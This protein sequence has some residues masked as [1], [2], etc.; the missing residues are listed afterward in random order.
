MADEL[1]VKSI[2]GASSSGWSPELLRALDTAIELA[3]KH[4]I[5]MLAIVVGERDG[6]SVWL[7]PQL[8]DDVN[9]AAIIETIA[10]A[11]K[12]MAKRMRQ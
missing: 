8:A 4:D 12:V 6:P 2:S 3:S 5:D 7:A 11:F 9:R 10:K 1:K